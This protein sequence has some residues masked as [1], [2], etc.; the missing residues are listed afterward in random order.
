MASIDWKNLQRKLN[1][2]IDLAR[3]FGKCKNCKHWYVGAYD[4]AFCNS[5]KVRVDVGRN[6][7][8]PELFEDQCLIPGGAR[9]RTG[10]EFGCLHFEP[11]ESEE[12]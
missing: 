2:A 4:G 10:P 6:E 8:L 1:E 5:P 12:Q 7:K 3:S 11:I 9:M